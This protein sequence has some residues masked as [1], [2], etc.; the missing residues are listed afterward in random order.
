MILCLGY[1]GMPKV[2]AEGHPGFPP[3]TQWYVEGVAPTRIKDGRH[4]LYLDATNK[5]NSG[6]PIFHHDEQSCRAYVIGVH[7]GFSKMVANMAVPIC[8]HME[9]SE[10]FMTQKL[11]DHVSVKAIDETGMSAYLS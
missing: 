7:V 6:S 4:L 3:G 11:L 5:G 10:N 1:P 9:T 2:E 8:Y